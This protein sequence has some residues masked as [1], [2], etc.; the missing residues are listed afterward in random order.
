M[1]IEVGF[2]IGR[3]EELRV[4]RGILLELGIVLGVVIVV[5]VDVDWVG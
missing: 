5:I 2:I 4:G 1:R 3:V